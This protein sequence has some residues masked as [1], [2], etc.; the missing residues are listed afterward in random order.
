[1]PKDKTNYRPDVR[2][3]VGYSAIEI[4]RGRILRAVDYGG[5]EGVFI[6]IN[7]PTEQAEPIPILLTPELSG[8]LAHSQG[9]AITRMPLKL[10]EICRRLT[11]QKGDK[12]KLQRGDKA[13]LR[14]VVR[15]LKDWEKEDDEEKS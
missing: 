6:V 4:K 5:L 8:W 14:E 10:L 12:V 9:Q 2:G 11:R 13:A 15:I 7:H 3:R 1:M